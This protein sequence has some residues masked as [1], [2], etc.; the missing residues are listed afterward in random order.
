MFVR[1]NK[2]RVWAASATSTW[3][4]LL[5]KPLSVFTLVFLR[6]NHNVNT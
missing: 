2:I 1:R 5:Q 4:E 3:Y 6:I